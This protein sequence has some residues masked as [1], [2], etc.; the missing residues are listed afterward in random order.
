MISIPIMEFYR[1]SLPPELILD[2]FI[3]GFESSYEDYLADFVNKSK[4]FAELSGGKEYYHLPKKKQSHGECDCCSENYSLDFKMFGAKSSL[5]ASRN[6]SLHKVMPCP[7]VIMKCPPEQSEDMDVALTN[8][9]LRAYYLDDLIKI[10]G[11]EF[12]NFDR[13]HLCP[14]AEV[15]AILKGMKYSKNILYF[16]KDFIFTERE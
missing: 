15:K 1:G 4:I 3:Q 12:P 16:Y 8:D 2:N 11:Q 5:Y 14:E 7:G 9:L 10:D 13:D 6:L